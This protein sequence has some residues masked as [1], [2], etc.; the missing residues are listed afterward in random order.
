MLINDF[1]KFLKTRMVLDVFT[2]VNTRYCPGY[3]EYSG[4]GWG[5]LERYRWV[6]TYEQ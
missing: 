4:T 6:C 3:F 1:G 5:I 2:P